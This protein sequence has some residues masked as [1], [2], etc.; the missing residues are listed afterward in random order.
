MRNAVSSVAGR[1]LPSVYCVGGTQLSVADPPA[2]AADTVM[3]K[4]GNEAEAPLLSVTVITMS[5]QLPVAVGVQLSCPVA[6]LKV[7]PAGFA[8][9]DQVNTSPSG[10]L[11]VGVKL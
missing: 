10:S 6:T 3:E 1:A 7:A 2:A 5:F 4:E 9:I 11:A 8:V